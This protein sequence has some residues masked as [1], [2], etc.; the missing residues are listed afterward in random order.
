M[1]DLILSKLLNENISLF[2]LI[3]GINNSFLNWLMPIITD[4]G[5][6]VAWI[7]IC[8]F[9]YIFGGSYGRKVAVLCLMALFL[10]NIL[11]ILLKYLVAEPRPFF[12]LQNVNLLIHVNGSS[13]PSGHTASSFAAATMIGL[14]YHLK[15]EGKKYYLIYLLLAFAVL[16][17]FSRIYLGVHYPYDVIFGA[18]I[19]TACTLII[20]KYENR[21]LNNK[22]AVRL[23]KTKYLTL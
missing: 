22:I 3:N 14:K 6:S 4:F 21:I 11:V 5:S 17:G 18:L 7:L 16:I 8:I 23:K 1:F 20:L 19:G 9:I 15:S 2:Y 12:T 10:T 13:F